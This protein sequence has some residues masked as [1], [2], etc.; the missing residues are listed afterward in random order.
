MRK[1][2][3]IIIGVMLVAQAGLAEASK[4]ELDKFYKPVKAN[5]LVTILPSQVPDDLGDSTSTFFSGDDS[6]CPDVI[7]IGSVNSDTPVYGDVDINVV[8]TSDIVV[9]CGGL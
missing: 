6:G 1:F 3:V 7:S 2:A 8:I 4:S 9:Q 5:D